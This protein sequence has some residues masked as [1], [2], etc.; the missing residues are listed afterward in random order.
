MLRRTYTQDYCQ[1]RFLNRKIYTLNTPVDRSKSI[2]LGSKTLCE[3]RLRSLSNDRDVNQ[4]TNY[5]FRNLLATYNAVDIVLF[6][7]TNK[8]DTITPLVEDHVVYIFGGSLRP[9]QTAFHPYFV[10]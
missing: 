6:C 5:A 7:I 3:L 10:Q 4:N 9:Q 1:Y 8:S 2:P